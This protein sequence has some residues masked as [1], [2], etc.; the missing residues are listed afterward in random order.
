V[1][2]GLLVSVPFGGTLGALIERELGVAP[3]PPAG[4][5]G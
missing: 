1:L 5:A 3:R 2:S 4:R